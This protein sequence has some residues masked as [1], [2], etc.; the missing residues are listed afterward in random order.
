MWSVV[1]LLDSER[2]DDLWIN[3]YDLMDILCR[4]H[5]SDRVGGGWE[6]MRERLI[7]FR[8]NLPM[9]DRWIVLDNDSPIAWEDF[10]IHKDAKGKPLAY[11]HMDALIDPVPPEIERMLADNLIGKFRKHEC[12]LCFIMTTNERISRVANNW[13]A[14]PQSK[15]VRYRLRRSNA[16]VDLMRG[17]I[18]TIPN[19][20]PDIRIEFFK[21]IPDELLNYFCELYTRFIAD[22]PG[23]VESEVEHAVSADEWR[24]RNEWRKK[25]NIQHYSYLMFDRNELI[26]FTNAAIYAGDAVDIYQAM[27]GVLPEYRGRGL[28]KWLKAALYLKLIEDFPENETVTTDMRAVNEPIQRLNANMG[29]ERVTEG[30]EFALRVE[31]LERYLSTNPV[32]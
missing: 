22:M 19:K 27:T 21:F 29:Y 6:R 13:G 2:D 31:D 1:S 24:K 3:Y 16:N 23:E 25:N 8:E 26:G 18:D 12:T 11:T 9:Y 20:H 4:E 17:W 15:I 32:K 14:K 5:G 10:R 30:G 28:G 7:S